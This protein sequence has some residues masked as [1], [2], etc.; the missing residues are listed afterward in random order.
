MLSPARPSSW[1]PWTAGQWQYGDTSFPEVGVTF[2]AG[3]FVRHP[4]ALA[5]ATA[6]LTHL[7][8]NGPGLQQALTERAA[9]TA[10]V[11][12][13]HIAEFDAPYHVTQFSSLMHLTFPPEQR[14]AGLL[15]YLLRERGIHTWENRLFVL[16]TAHSDEDIA[17]LTRAFRES[18]AELQSQGFFGSAGG[19]RVRTSSPAREALASAPADLST[20]ASQLASRFP[21]TEAQREIWLAAQMGGDAAVAYNESLS[22]KFRGP[23]AVDLFRQAVH[24][25]V[26]RHPILLAG[27]S[28]DGLWQEIHFSS[29]IDIPLD[30]LSSLSAG[31]QARPSRRWSRKR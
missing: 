26:E 8:Q 24:H 5:A 31:G 27:I 16:T 3:T 12:R 10:D 21:L 17:S 25:V 14:Y 4:L 23:F 2:F 13:S 28:E 6:V 18:L 15:F 9:A 29:T 22:L 1:T 20:P 7:K 11:L 30:D 19:P